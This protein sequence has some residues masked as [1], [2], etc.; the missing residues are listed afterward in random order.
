MDVY[1]AI[2]PLHTVS[3]ILGV[4]SFSIFG[5]P[6][7][8]TLKLYTRD[9][10]LHVIK[11]LILFSF[12]LKE[13]KFYSDSFAKDPIDNI[14]EIFQLYS[15]SFMTFIYVTNCQIFYKTLMDILISL[16]QT[17]NLLNK[18]QLYPNYKNEIIYFIILVFFALYVISSLTIINLIYNTFVYISGIIMFGIMT[19]IMLTLQM[20][21]YLLL[22]D[23]RTRFDLI[24]T[25]LKH[26][27]ND[28]VTLYIDYKKE[29]IMLNILQDIVYVHGFI[30]HICRKVNFVFNI[31]LTSTIGWCFCSGVISLY[32][33]LRSDL[34]QEKLTQK[35]VTSY[36][37]IMTMFNSCCVV[38]GSVKVSSRVKF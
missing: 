32:Y 4:N 26:I 11:L 17:D 19:L 16:E 38:A 3:K 10:I 34:M 14:L 35:F 24:N 30:Y 29:A 8:R 37:C 18:L 1:T 33:N 20:Y 25:K 6:K 15:L 13:R 2:I 22:Y 31:S 27:S 21:C 23:L 7:C 12:F 28:K 36:W 5:K 9:V